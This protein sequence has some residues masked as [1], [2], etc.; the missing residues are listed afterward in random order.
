MIILSPVIK[1]NSERGAPF[2]SVLSETLSVLSADLVKSCPIKTSVIPAKLS[3]QHYQ[4]LHQRYLNND[5]S[6][7]KQCSIAYEFFNDR[8]VSFFNFS[9]IK[10]NRWRRLVKENKSQQ[11]KQLCNSRLGFNFSP[12][13]APGLRSSQNMNWNGIFKNDRTGKKRAQPMQ[14]S[15][16]GK[17]TAT[18][19]CAK[20]PVSLNGMR[21]MWIIYELNTTQ[22]PSPNLV[23]E[24]R[25]EGGYA[26]S[27]RTPRCI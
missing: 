23:L 15:Q 5:T 22:A 7:S 9:G 16:L 14:P 6:P 25:G 17:E 19:A 1:K 8:V 20:E 2:F 10:A 26:G 3:N 21:R 4:Q 27:M 18:S 24:G 12:D 11:V 13:D